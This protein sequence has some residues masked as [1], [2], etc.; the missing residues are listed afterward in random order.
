MSKSTKRPMHDHSPAAIADRLAAG[1]GQV[2]LKD[3]VYGAIDGAV[4]TLAVVSGV[5]GGGLASSVIIVLGLANIFADGFSM[6]I[7]N[8]LGTRAE[9][10]RLQSV[11]TTEE[12][13]IDIDPEGEREEIRQIYAGKGFSGQQLEQ[14]VR[15]IT[16][17][18]R[19]WV[20]A[21]VQEEYGLSLQGVHPGMA[22]FVTFMAFL[23]SGLLPL[24]PFLV[25]W[26][27]EGLIADPFSLSVAITMLAFFVVG[28]MKG[29]YVEQSW[30]RSGLETAVVGGIAALLAYGVGVLLGDLVA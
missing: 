25:N 5:A 24:T 6:A 27:R 20:D 2:Y 4:T 16:S 26:W 21:M 12:G 18:R 9:N 11:R 19:R 13:H 22:G 23:L 17:D 8:Y 14:I 1:P 3:F 30:Y 15:V 7:S 29:R 28:A 10:Q